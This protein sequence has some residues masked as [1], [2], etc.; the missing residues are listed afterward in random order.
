MFLQELFKDGCEVNNEISDREEYRSG[1][2]DASSVCQ[3]PLHRAV[4]P[5]FS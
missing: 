1:D 2:I 3:E 5:V 4:S